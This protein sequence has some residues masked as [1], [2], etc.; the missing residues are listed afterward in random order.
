MRVPSECMLI[1]LLCAPCRG[2]WC[3]TRFESLAY[4]RLAVQAQIS[5]SVKLE[6]ILDSV[7]SIETVR[8]LSGHPILARAALEN[9][10]TWRFSRCTGPDGELTVSFEY[11]FELQR[12][13]DPRPV[14]ILQ[15]E[16]PYKVKVTARSESWQP[17]KN[18]AADP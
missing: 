15:Y 9:I 13:N 12:A 11:K 10:R 6:V 14:P 1:L 17:I 16:H 3:A 7:G 4:P 5:G 8:A 2:D 18:Q